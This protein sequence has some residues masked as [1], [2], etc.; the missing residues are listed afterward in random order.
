MFRSWQNSLQNLNGI[1]EV[2]TFY[3]ELGQQRL[4][5]RNKIENRIKYLYNLND[6]YNKEDRTFAKIVKNLNRSR[7]EIN[8]TLNVYEKDVKRFNLRE[9][10]NKVITQYNQKMAEN[11][12][13]I[14]QNLKEVDNLEKIRVELFEKY[15]K[16]SLHARKILQNLQQRRIQQGYSSRKFKKF[17]LFTADQSHVDDQCSI[18]MDNFEIGR[19][20][21]RL[22]CDGKHTFCKD[23]IIRW[24]ANHNTCPIC[25]HNF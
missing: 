13:R 5:F 21:V 1:N 16:I 23:C 24:L 12:K 14:K 3:N 22:N 19:N 10:N 4:Q 20:M 7:G 11:A 9:Q 8:K 6:V 2:D 15:R 17:P 18:C 25:R